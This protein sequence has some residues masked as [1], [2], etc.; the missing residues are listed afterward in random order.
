MT[1]LDVYWACNGKCDSFMDKKVWNEFQAITAWESIEELA[2]PLMY[3]QWI[4]K[5]LTRIRDGLE[6]Y[7]DEAFEH[8]RFLVMCLSQIVVK[9]TVTGRNVWRCKAG[10]NGGPL[11]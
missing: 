4:G 2:I 10:I 8:F 5:H 1:I 6:V 7:T 9:D 11:M 3:M